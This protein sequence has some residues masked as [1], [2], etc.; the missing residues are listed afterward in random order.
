MQRPRTKLARPPIL[1]RLWAMLVRPRTVSQFCLA[2]LLLIGVLAAILVV[3]LAIDVPL[4]ALPMAII[5]ASCFLGAAWC[6]RTVDGQA[7][8][9]P[10]YRPGFPVQLVEQATGPSD[11]P[12]DGGSPPAA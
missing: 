2:L 1:F 12:T 10:T 9:D 6:A 7:P 3:P 4:A 8:P 5:A 11:R